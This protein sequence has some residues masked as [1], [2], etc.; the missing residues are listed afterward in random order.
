MYKHITLYYI[1]VHNRYNQ[2]FMLRLTK[3]IKIL[4]VRSYYNVVKYFKS[5]ISLAYYN[6]ISYIFISKFFHKKELYIK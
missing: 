3:T 4:R 1:L 6:L 5:I 2:N